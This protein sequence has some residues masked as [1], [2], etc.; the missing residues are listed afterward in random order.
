[1]AR[2]GRARLAPPLRRPGL[3]TLGLPELQL[4]N[5]LVPF[6]EQLGGHLLEFT[7]NVEAIEDF[8]DE[9]MMIEEKNGSQDQKEAGKEFLRKNLRKLMDKTRNSIKKVKPL[10]LLQFFNYGA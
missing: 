5:E 2:R 1:M 3:L 7:I 9:E 8:E 6:L 10:H 4:V